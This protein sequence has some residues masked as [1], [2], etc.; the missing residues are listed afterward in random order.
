VWTYIWEAV[1]RGFEEKTETADSLFTTGSNILQTLWRYVSTP[2]GLDDLEVYAVA[3]QFTYVWGLWNEKKSN[4]EEFSK[5]IPQRD[6]NYSRIQKVELDEVLKLRTEP[7]KH[8][9]IFCKN[10]FDA[11]QKIMDVGDKNLPHSLIPSWALLKAIMYEKMNYFYDAI[12]Y[13]KIAFAA[14]PLDV[15]E[16]EIR[17]SYESYIRTILTGAQDDITK[18]AQ[19]FG[20]LSTY[21]DVDN[22]F[23]KETSKDIV[24]HEVKA[25]IQ[26]HEQPKPKEDVVTHEVKSDIQIPEQP[27]PASAAQGAKADIQIP[28][29]HAD[30]SKTV[31]IEKESWDVIAEEAYKLL[32]EK[33]KRLIANKVGKSL[34]EETKEGAAEMA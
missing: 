2:V 10:L 21:E 31:S 30:T 32:D 5:S 16:R 15:N 17:K 6:H 26:I 3:K 8:M 23:P 20:D 11:D 12:H 13:W 7:I 29:Q 28:E 9:K 34:E 27:P 22:D 14:R 4:M 25:G 33:T 19:A 24:A 1:L 18:L